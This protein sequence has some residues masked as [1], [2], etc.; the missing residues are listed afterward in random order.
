MSFADF[1]ERFESCDI[2]HVRPSF[3]YNF[4]TCASDSRHGIYFEVD[5]RSERATECY[6]SLHQ[7]S[8][9]ADVANLK[10]LRYSRAT[11]VVAMRHSSGTY[12]YI[13]SKI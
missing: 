10:K 9:R 8:L 6:F 7:D 4:E 5:I 1:L 11:M 12:H 3:S 2:S 13:A